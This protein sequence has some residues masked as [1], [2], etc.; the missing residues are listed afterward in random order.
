MSRAGKFIPGGGSKGDGPS[1]AKRT[2]PIRAPEPGAPV[3]DPAAAKKSLIKG[4]S[5]IRPVSKNQR[6]PIMLMSAG[7]F[8]LLLT[9][10][11]YFFAVLPNKRE[12]A[13]LQKEVDDANAATQKAQADLLAQQQEQAKQKATEHATLIVDTKPT[14]ATVTIGAA[15]KQTPATFDGLDPGTV[16]MTIR[17]D[18]YEDYKQDVTVSVDKPADLGVIELM[19]KAGNLSL[20]S[21]QTGVGYSLTGPG[22]YS[23]EGQVPEKLEKLPVGDYQ[24]VAT[25]GDWKLAPVTITIHDRENVQREIKFPYASLTLTSEPGGATVREGHTI[26][27]KTPLSLTNLRPRT[28]HLTLDLPPYTLARFD[29]PVPDFGNIT[30]DVPLQQDKDFIASCGM[31]M[32]WISDGGFW[33]GK[34]LMRQGDFETVAGYNPSFFR[35]PTRPVEQIS[36]ESAMAF[37]DKLTEF[38]RKAGRLPAGYHYTLP[39]ESQWSA[40]SADADLNQA[41]MSR[42]NSLDSTQD[43]GASEPNKYGLYDTLGNVWEWCLDAFDDKGDHSLRGGSWLSSADN[44]PSADTRNAGGPKYTDRFTGFRVVLVP[45]TQ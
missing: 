11:I 9:G 1:G 17:A 16:T 27:G 10:T 29:L 6:L 30:K 42:T 19:L 13:E 3:P 14:G 34:Y 40:F 23:H 5:L 21:P 32:V 20:T 36:W 2:G 22:D 37:C 43:V 31:P 45:Q 24:L 28:M 41:P 33:A 38:E 8:I 7:V 25:Q 44:F 18:G 35:R 12:V 15:Q 4:S 26:L 39:T